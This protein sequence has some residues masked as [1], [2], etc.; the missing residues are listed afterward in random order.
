MPPTSNPH[1]TLGPGPKAQVSGE[2]S[3]VWEP[4]G[5]PELH[6]LSTSLGEACRVA[7]LPT[8]TMDTRVLW[9]QN[10][11]LWNHKF[12]KTYL[13]PENVPCT[14]SVICWLATRV[15]ESTGSWAAG[16]LQSPATLPTTL[17]APRP[18]APL[19]TPPS[20]LPL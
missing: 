19:S 18:P 7:F 11:L 5:N 4:Q 20:P 1:I 16:P 14:K 13:E 2:H 15:P 3:H 8:R 12:Y 9:T 17:L 10:L 6:N